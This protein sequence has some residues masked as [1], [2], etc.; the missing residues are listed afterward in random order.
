MFHAIL[1]RIF[2]NLGCLLESMYNSVSKEY[3]THYPIVIAWIHIKDYRE[4][5]HFSQ[6]NAEIIYKRLTKY[7]FQ[8]EYF[9]FTSKP[10]KIENNCYDMNVAFFSRY[11][12]NQFNLK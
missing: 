1:I 11:L 10:I 8:E 3:G 9:H 2:S 5:K 12:Y 6:W 7:T 4:K